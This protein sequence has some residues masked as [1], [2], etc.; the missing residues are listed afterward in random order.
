MSEYTLNIVN[1]NIKITKWIKS[2]ARLGNS[3]FTYN[4]STENFFII[5]VY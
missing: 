5:V 3:I 2:K 1:T 4:I